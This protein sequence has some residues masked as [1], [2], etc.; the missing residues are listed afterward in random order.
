MDAAETANSW[1]LSVFWDVHSCSR[2]KSFYGTS[3]TGGYQNRKERAVFSISQSFIRLRTIYP[4]LEC[5]HIHFTAFI[6]L[7]PCGSTAFFGHRNCGGECATVYCTV[8]SPCGDGPGD[9]IS[10]N[11]IAIDLNFAQMGCEFIFSKCH[12]HGKASLQRTGDL[13]RLQLT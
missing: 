10:V 9:W 2:L 12:K 13:E 5:C 11:L 4:A 8:W 6:R 3:K 7:G 1:W